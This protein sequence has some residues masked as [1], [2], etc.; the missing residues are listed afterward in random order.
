M[1]DLG[2]FH[3]IKGGIVYELEREEDGT[4][5]VNVPALPECISV[6]DTVEEALDMIQEAMGLWL[7]VAREEGFVIPRQFELQESS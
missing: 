1:T 3:I 7:E 4:Y 2:V 6:G 5:G